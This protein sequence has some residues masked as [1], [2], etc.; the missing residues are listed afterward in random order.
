MGMAYS[1]A[2]EEMHDETIEG[3]DAVVSIM[4]GIKAMIERGDIPADSV[5][6]LM[7]MHRILTRNQPID[8]DFNSFFNK[9]PFSPPESTGK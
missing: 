2:V 7:E 8:F 5:P 3:V 1:E 4:P 6:L 9:L